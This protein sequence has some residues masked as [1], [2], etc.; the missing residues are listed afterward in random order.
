MTDRICAADGCGAPAN[1]SRGYCRRHYTRLLKYGRTDDATLSIRSPYAAA[2]QC[3]IEGCDRDASAKT[4]LC[5]RHY[6]RFKRWGDPEFRLNHRGDTVEQRL[7]AYR[8][9]T[10]SGCWEW[11]GARTKRGYGLI[12][13]DGKALRA[14][15]AS[16]R[17]FV[18]DV[19]PGLELD[20]LC[21][22]R[23]CFNP[24]HLEAVPH[25]VNSRRAEAAGLIPHPRPT[26]CK[27]GHEFTPENTYVKPSSGRRE[28]RTC[29]RM[30]RR[31]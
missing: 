3:R 29:A 11:T 14:H 12:R 9:I 5:P 24:A 15:Q 23:A 20:H 1:A 13:V 19:P 21:M 26:H 25:A 10:E 16:Y 17:V 31:R 6:A 22:N 30:P 8:R 2:P 27:R 28:C 7:L 4:G 18:G